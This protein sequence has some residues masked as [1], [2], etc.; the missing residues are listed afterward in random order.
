MGGSKQTDPTNP[1]KPLSVEVLRD[2]QNKFLDALNHET[3]L[4]CVLIATSFLE[5]CLSTLLHAFTIKADTSDE[6]RDYRR[7]VLRDMRLPS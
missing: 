5:Q 4:A 2:Q 1:K 7:G 3:P 6:L